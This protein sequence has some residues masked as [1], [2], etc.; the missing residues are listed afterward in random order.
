MVK[1][2]RRSAAAAGSDSARVVASTQGAV[3][4]T[5]PLGEIT[6]CDPADARLS[7]YAAEW[8]ANRLAGP[9]VVQ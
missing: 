3:V 1:D 5:T 9:P 4:G 7:G 6:G 2:L 8:A